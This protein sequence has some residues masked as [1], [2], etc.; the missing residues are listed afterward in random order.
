MTSTLIDIIINR[1]SVRRYK[2]CQITNGELDT[3]LKAG[4][5]APSGGNNQSTTFLVI[6]NQQILK[7]L[8][9]LVEK[10]FASM[11]VDEN[12]YKSL[13]NSINLSKNG[14]YCFYHNAPTL[15]V[16]AN[17]KGYCN[18]FADCAVAIENMMLAATTLGIG[19]C[20]INQLVWLDKNPAVCEFMRKLGIAQYEQICGAVA[21][22]YADQGVHG[23]LE[24]T[25]NPV[26]YIR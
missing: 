16:T 2:S 7:E 10:E 12:M 17:K 25:G 21:F 3:I 13:K 26:I 6:Q 24:R 8:A 1:R 20:W 18:A 14:G 15:V 22:G 19:S 4:R 5:Y 9:L 23:P 11:S